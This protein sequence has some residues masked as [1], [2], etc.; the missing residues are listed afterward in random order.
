MPALNMHEISVS[1]GC[2]LH[3]HAVVN[4]M[5]FPI[6]KSTYCK[7]FSRKK[8]MDPRVSYRTFFSGGGGGGGEFRKPV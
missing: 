4:E 2:G 1:G 8:V 5:I 6:L 7:K 3:C